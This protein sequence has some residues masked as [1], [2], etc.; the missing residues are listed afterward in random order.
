MLYL[1]PFYAAGRRAKSDEL[2]AWFGK[3]RD[4]DAQASQQPRGWLRKMLCF[5]LRFQAR[6]LAFSVEVCGGTAYKAGG[7]WLPCP[8]RARTV[9]CAADGLWHFHKR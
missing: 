4:V 9:R 8:R 6:L 5:V 2:V 1:L 7:L 3:E